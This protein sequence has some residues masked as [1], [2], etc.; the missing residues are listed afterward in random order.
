M[1]TNFVALK[2]TKDELS[3]LIDPLCKLMLISL[4]DPN[5]AKRYLTV[6]DFDFFEKVAG[7]V[8][9]E[10]AVQICAVLETYMLRKPC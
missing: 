5:L 3:I 10:K 1:M 9:V 4:K 8:S 7:K 2:L 6:E